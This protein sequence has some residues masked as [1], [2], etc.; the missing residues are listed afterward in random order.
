MSGLDSDFMYGQQEYKYILI[1][2]I[3]TRV[4][5][6]QLSDTDIMDEDRPSVIFNFQL[7]LRISYILSI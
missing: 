5:E 7:V 3:Y 4:V 6:P 2:P 1:G